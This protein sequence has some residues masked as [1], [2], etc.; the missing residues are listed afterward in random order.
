MR[1]LV[2]AFIMSGLDYGNALLAGLSLSSFEVETFNLVILHFGCMSPNKTSHERITP[3]VLHFGS[4][5][6]VYDLLRLRCLLFAQLQLAVL[7]EL[8]QCRPTTRRLHGYIRL[9]ITRSANSRIRKLREQ[10]YY[11]ETISL[12]CKSFMF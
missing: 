7:L 12:I 4:N 2:H 8:F 11:I 6:I 3:Y 10:H 1:S 9:S 5:G